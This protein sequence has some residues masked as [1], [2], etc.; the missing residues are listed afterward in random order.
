MFYICNNEVSVFE[1]REGRRKGIIFTVG[2][3]KFRVRELE[4]GRFVCSYIL[5]FYMYVNIEGL[6]LFLS[7]L[8]R[9]NFVC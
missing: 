2:E 3:G 5:S 7:K 1:E 8:R 9:L 6:S 4:V